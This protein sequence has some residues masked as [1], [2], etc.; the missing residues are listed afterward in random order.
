M[1]TPI[2]SSRGGGRG[3]I[4]FGGPPFNCGNP[5]INVG[6]ETFVIRAALHDVNLWTRVPHLRPAIGPRLSVQIVTSPRPA[7]VI[8]RDPATGNAIGVSA[9]DGRTRTGLR[10]RPPV[11]HGG[12]SRRS[13]CRLPDRD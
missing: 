13:R 4:R 10:Q 7:A 12:G 11:R 6:P 1:P 8:N 3:E 2:C 9:C 5:P